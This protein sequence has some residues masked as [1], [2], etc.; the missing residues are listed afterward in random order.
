MFL[1]YYQAKRVMG[2]FL[3]SGVIGNPETTMALIN[4]TAAILRKQNYKGYIHLKI[5]PG[6]SN[7]AIEESLSLASTVS[8]NVETVGEKRFNKI[9]NSKS[10]E[11]D[12]VRPIKFIGENTARGSRYSRVT[13]TTQFIVGASDETDREIIRCTWGLYKRVGLNRVYFSAYQ[14]GL[15][16]PDLPGESSSYSNSALLT[17]EHR[18]YQV[19]WLIRQYHFQIDEIPFE[20]DGNI[21]LVMDPKEAWALR[22]PEFFPVN[23]NT[24]DKE[25]LLRVP[26]LGEVTVN[27][28]L[29]YRKNHCRLRS[30]SDFL[31]PGKQMEKVK[32]YII[33]S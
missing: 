26:G 1:S 3:S 31:V 11:S 23:V 10:Y 29:N 2:L 17:R 32:S 27:K 25:V 7:A 18:L 13:Q 21:S 28:I 20:A 15:G 9:C 14:R 19:D 12:I 33:F 22:H 30:I 5:I 24:A 8:L 4:K 6:A 16:E